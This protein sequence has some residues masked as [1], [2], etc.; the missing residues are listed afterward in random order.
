MT[1]WLAK[2]NRQVEGAI[3]DPPPTVPAQQGE[4][5]ATS[6][7]NSRGLSDTVAS[8]GMRPA[9]FRNY[10]VYPRRATRHVLRERSTPYAG[11][12][13]AAS[14]FLTST[15]SRPLPASQLDAARALFN[16]CTWEHLSDHGPP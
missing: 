3:D 8:T 14:E 9:S 4:G 16:S 13:E 6:R 12:L 10:R 7:G 1:N 15:Y 5:A 2:A 11:S